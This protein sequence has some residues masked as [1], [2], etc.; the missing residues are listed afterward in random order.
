MFLILPQEHYPEVEKGL[1]AIRTSDEPMTVGLYKLVRELKKNEKTCRKDDLVHGRRYGVF[2]ISHFANAWR[3][4]RLILNHGEVYLYVWTLG[5][6]GVFYTVNGWG[7][8]SFSNNP[9]GGESEN[10]L[11]EIP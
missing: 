8:P 7:T 2:G 9:S 4:G 6:D 3:D 1:N 11:V 5:E 10:L